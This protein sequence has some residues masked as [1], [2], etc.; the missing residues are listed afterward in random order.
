M[1]RNGEAV[2]VKVQYPNLSA[3]MAADQRALRVLSWLVERA[4]PGCGY[5]WLLPE[6]EDSMR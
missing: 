1:T 2:A 6:F 3:Q 4:F 5:E